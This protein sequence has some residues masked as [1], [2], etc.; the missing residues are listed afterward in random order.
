[1][2]KKLKIFQ[3]AFRIYIYIYIRDSVHIVQC[4]FPFSRVEQERSGEIR[5]VE[6]LYGCL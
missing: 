2:N 1:M 4:T 5:I 6:V 3:D